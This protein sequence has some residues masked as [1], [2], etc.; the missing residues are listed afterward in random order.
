MARLTAFIPVGPVEC[1]ATVKADLTQLEGTLPG[2]ECA[3]AE[4]LL[5]DAQI[6][7]FLLH[8]F[9]KESTS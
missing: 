1:P 9:I 2:F 3:M 4:L 8:L 5:S 6:I 7:K